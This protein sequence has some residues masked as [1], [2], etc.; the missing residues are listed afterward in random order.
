MNKDRR[1]VL[2]ECLAF[3]LSYIAISDDRHF[4]RSTRRDMIVQCLDDL[5]DLDRETL[6][7]ITSE[8]KAIGETSVLY[9]DVSCD[10]VRAI[11]GRIA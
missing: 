8:L 3:L 9:K 5:A 10:L 4:S 7:L 6:E 11:M 2:V 1:I